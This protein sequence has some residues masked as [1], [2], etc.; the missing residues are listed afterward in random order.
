MALCYVWYDKMRFKVLKDISP[1]RKWKVTSWRDK[2]RVSFFLSRSLC[3]VFA[4]K[5]PLSHLVLEVSNSCKY[6]CIA[7]SGC[8][9]AF[10]DRLFETS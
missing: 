5:S 3:V 9:I 1:L 6:F 8:K 10:E 4:V 2:L 7:E